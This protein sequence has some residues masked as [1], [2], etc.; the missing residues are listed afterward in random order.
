[1]FVCKFWT[2][3]NNLETEAEDYK[4]LVKVKQYGGGGVFCGAAGMQKS[5]WHQ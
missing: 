5:Q 2:E 3:L 1:M 4:V